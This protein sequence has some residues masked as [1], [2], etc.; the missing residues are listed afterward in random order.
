M[1]ERVHLY[2]G[3]PGVPVGKIAWYIK[4]IPIG[5]RVHNVY[6]LTLWQRTPSQF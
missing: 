6:Q 1:G 4:L 3:P 2:R 5:K